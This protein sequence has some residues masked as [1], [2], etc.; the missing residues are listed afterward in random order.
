MHNVVLR[1]DGKI[2]L[3]GLSESDRAEIDA[4]LADETLI[5]Y[6]L[7]PEGLSDPW[8]GPK[9]ESMASRLVLTDDP[10]DEALCTE[11]LPPDSTVFMVAPWVAEN[12]WHT[13][14]DIIMPMFFNVWLADTLSSDKA[15]NNVLYVFN[16]GLARAVIREL[17]TFL[18]R[19]LFGGGIRSTSELSASPDARICIPRLR[20]GRG[21]LLLYLNDEVFPALRGKLGSPDTAW[22]HFSPGEIT[23]AYRAHVWQQLGIEPKAPLD[24][25]TGMAGNDQVLNGS[26]TILV[27]R[28]S[29]RSFRLP[30]GEDAF[31]DALAA[32]PH[33]DVVSET[34]AGSFTDTITRFASVDVVMGASGAGLIHTLYAPPH[35]A[36]VDLRLSVGC[37]PSFHA[38]TAH[39][40]SLRYLEIWEPE[41]EPYSLD[42]LARDL[43]VVLEQVFGL[44]S[45]RAMAGPFLSNE[46]AGLPAFLVGDG[47]SKATA[48]SRCRPF[49]AES[50]MGP[51][52]MCWH[53]PSLSVPATSRAF[54]TL[55]A[56]HIP[57]TCFGRDRVVLPDPDDRDTR[58]PLVDIA[59]GRDGLTPRLYPAVTVTDESAA[60]GR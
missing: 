20:Y 43:V 22:Q 40:A 18:E 4:G 47:E 36:L 5:P 27:P 53:V 38:E 41:Y 33:L 12:A 26:R 23:T 25:M 57:L 8:Q 24:G 55:P 54:I 46:A 30:D 45:R 42:Q 10:V 3:G 13:H 16:P 7:W 2:E 59:P 31:V 37:Q 14:N 19:I 34:F 49:P 39:H 6:K 51:R 15:S 1:G 58:F 32:Y 50:G 9:T 28:R 17:P 29:S 35:A 11:M 60:A 44:W 52:A 21:P 48:T 56:P